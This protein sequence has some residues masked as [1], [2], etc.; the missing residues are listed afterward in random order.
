MKSLS[1]HYGSPGR[2]VENKRQF[3]RAFQRPGDDPS[4]FAIE[5][6]TLA[7]RAFVDIDSSVQL[8]MVRDH[9]IDGQA[10][11]ALR[12][13]LNSL[14]PDTP[15]RD[16]VDSCRVW[17]NH[18]E[19]A[20]SRQVRLDRHSPNVVC[21]VTEDSQS[22]AVSR[23]RDAGR[24]HVM[25]IAEADGAASEGGPYSI[26][27]GAA[28]TALAGGHTATSASDTG[29][30][31]VDGYGNCVAEL[32]SGQISHGGGRAFVGAS[33]RVSGGVFFWWGVDPYDG[34]KSDAR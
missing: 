34:P 33:S 26:G 3:E 4:V 5:L 8:Q 29:A 11:C 6:E 30:V 16:I 18:I 19:V 2:L 23:V 15:M 31:S 24:N 28:H 7:R 27:S 9:F 1:E 17:E 10:K 32:A 12:R 25:V 22:P 21:Q 14:G 13:H 20:S